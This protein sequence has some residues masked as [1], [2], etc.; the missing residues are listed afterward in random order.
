VRDAAS[1]PSE[2]SVLQHIVAT[3]LRPWTAECIVKL[4]DR[5]LQFDGPNPHLCGFRELV[6]EGRYGEQYGD[7]PHR[8]LFLSML[9][10]DVRQEGVR[11]RSRLELFSGWIDRKIE[12]DWLNPKAT[13]GA[14]RPP[15]REDG[16]ES[17][18]RTKTHAY[19]VMAAA[20]RK[21][22]SF[23]DAGELALLPTVTIDDVLSDGPAWFADVD[24]MPCNAKCSA[25]TREKN[26]GQCI[27]VPFRA[28]GVPRVLPRAQSVP[29]ARRNDRI[30]RAG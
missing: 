10:D 9:I 23:D 8:P 30:G 15:I 20:A 2:K 19:H 1:E 14:I 17:L 24:R 11:P 3:E 22:I 26:A 12:R 25:S 7:I 16:A 6:Q 4:V 21:M 29:G 27:A 13:G 18:D 5:S 28:P